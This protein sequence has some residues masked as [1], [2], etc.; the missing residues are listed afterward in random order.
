MIYQTTQKVY[1]ARVGLLVYSRTLTTGNGDW[2][3][4]T[5]R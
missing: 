3:F 1:G 4:L 2:S 5:R